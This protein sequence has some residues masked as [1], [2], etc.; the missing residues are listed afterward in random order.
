MTEHSVTEPVVLPPD[1]TLVPVDE[2]PE[3]LRAEIAHVAGDHAL[4]RPLSRHPS[5]IV[6]LRTAELLEGFRTPTRIVDAVI[7]YSTAQQLDPAETLEQAFPVLQGFMNAGLLVPADSDLAQPIETSLEPGAVVGGLEVVQAAHVMVDTE[8]YLAS[9][10]E[11]RRVA[12]KLARAGF[13]TGLGTAFAHEASILSLLD[14]SVTPA[15]IDRGEHEGRPYLALSW[16]D[17]GDVHEAAAEHRARGPAAREQLLALGVAIVEAYARI[18]EQGVLHGDVHPRNVLVDSSGR[19]TV[20]DFGL[21][22]AA[23]HP[24][25]G[26]PP[27]GGID[28]FMEPELA[29]AVLAREPPPPSEPQGEQYSIAALVYLLLTGAHTQRFS[30]EEP[31]MLRQLVDDPPLAFSAHGV[32]GLDAAE[33]VV[34]RA[35]AKDPAG[36]FEDVA[37]FG[38]AL[39]SAATALDPLPAPPGRIAQSTQADALLE[40]VLDRLGLSGELLVT[41]LEAPA[42]SLQNGAAGF[43]YALLRIAGARDDGELLALADVWSQR[44]L[45]TVPRPAAFTNEELDI[46]PA[47][48]GTRSLYHCETGVHWTD[49]LVALARCDDP[50]AAASVAEFVRCARRPHEHADLAFGP[51]GNLVGCALLLPHVTPTDRAAVVET[52]DDLRDSVLATIE[53]R[54][55]IPDDTQLRM[56]GVAHGWAG[57]LYA[58][59]L[60]GEATGLAPAEALLARLEELAVLAVPAHRGLRWPHAVGSE[61]DGLWP[62]W[63]NGSAGLTHLW[64]LAWRETGDDTF[65]TFAERAAWAAYEAPDGIADL[66][67]GLAGRAYA[68]LAAY[69]VAGDDA[70]LPRAHELADRAAAQVRRY[71]LRRDSLYKGEVGVAVLAADLARP[72]ESAMPAFEA[73]AWA[74]S[75]DPATRHG[76]SD[77]RDQP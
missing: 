17:G 33:R 28:F 46:T 60:W 41:T 75:T 14:G 66:C 18:H 68:A 22:R 63:C 9:T 61:P 71:A 34:L 45:E 55:P 62:S 8:V 32:T 7:D 27:R 70:W 76:G 52:G 50:A 12:L 74:R 25:L 31:E 21:G 23:S 43:A 56:L 5:T 64:A 10:P 6:D 65:A 77:G 59:L 51:A 30:L 49:A 24:T 2:L 29:A 42:A 15:V 3:E 26:T 44:A 57:L 69:K 39:R 13:E 16:C 53:G 4:T 54:P 36:R 73:D 72:L 67:C 37:A 1:A 19:V 48:F 35:L 40:V 20:I 58:I 11:G 47:T 38:D